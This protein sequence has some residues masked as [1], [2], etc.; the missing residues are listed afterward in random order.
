MFIRDG[1]LQSKRAVLFGFFSTSSKWLQDKLNQ[2][3]CS[4]AKHLC[5]DVFSTQQPPFVE[6]SGLLQGNVRIQQF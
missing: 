2:T 4:C 6:L 1:P 5:V 3:F